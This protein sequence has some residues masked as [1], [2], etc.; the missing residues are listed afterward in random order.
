VSGKIAERE[1]SGERIKSAAPATAPAA[2]LLFSLSLHVTQINR[3]CRINYGLGGS[4]E[5]GP[6]NSGGLIISQKYFLYI[7]NIHRKLRH[8]LIS[9][10][11]L[12]FVF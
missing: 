11:I 5:P 12:R 8:S 2:I 3:Q 9:I 4:P 6:L 1:R 7:Q 10:H